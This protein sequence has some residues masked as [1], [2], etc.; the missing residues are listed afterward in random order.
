MRTAKTYKVKIRLLGTRIIYSDIQ[1]QDK[2]CYVRQ[3]FEFE[4]SL[5][6]RVSSR[7]ARVTQSNPVSRKKVLCLR[8]W[9][10]AWR[11]ATVDAM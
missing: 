6:Y 2:K 5:V 9:S 11:T 7:I 4:A 1:Y 8:E 3:V 10:L